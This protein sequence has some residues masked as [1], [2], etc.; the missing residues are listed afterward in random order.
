VVK[1]LLPIHTTIEERAFSA[2]LIQPVILLLKTL[3]Y[4][5]YYLA[6]S[7]WSRP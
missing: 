7:G 4:I 5:G 1:I 3:V 2:Y 6:I